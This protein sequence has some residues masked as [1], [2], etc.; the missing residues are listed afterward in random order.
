MVQKSKASPP[1]NRRKVHRCSLVATAEVTDIGSGTTLSSRI[2]E[3][4]IGG[5]YVEALTPFPEGTQVKVRILRDTGTFETSG[6]VIHSDTNFGMG[7]AFS[8]IK[9]EQRSILETWLAEI[10][11]QLRS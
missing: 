11:N 2:S 6:T 8:E 10:V 1:P 9:H 7:L 4:S 3:L 5:C